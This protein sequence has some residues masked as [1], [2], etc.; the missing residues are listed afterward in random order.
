MPVATFEEIAGRVRAG[1]RLDRKDGVFLYEH[2]D[3]DAL[4]RLANE[5]AEA[6][7]GRIRYP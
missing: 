7:L 1:E 2:D 3:L 4:R 6:K 5:V